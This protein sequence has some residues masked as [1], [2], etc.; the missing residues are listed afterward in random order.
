MQTL[1]SKQKKLDWA[2]SA[3]S[4]CNPRVAAEED[5]KRQ[6]SCSIPIQNVAHLT[7][8]EKFLPVEASMHRY[9]AKRAEIADLSL[10]RA[11]S[12]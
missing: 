9:I 5:A 1:I 3:V 12:A 2:D 11:K 6:R 7:I 8:A 4:G 10:S